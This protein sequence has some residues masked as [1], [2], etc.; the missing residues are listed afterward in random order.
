MQTMD[1]FSPEYYPSIHSF[2]MPNYL[3]RHV[4]PTVNCILFQVPFKWAL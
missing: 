1:R 2:S 4:D 3:A